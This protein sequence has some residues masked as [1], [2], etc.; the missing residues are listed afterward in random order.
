M[1][2]NICIRTCVLFILI[3]LSICLFICGQFS[4]TTLQSSGSNVCLSVDSSLSLHSSPVAQMSVCL[5]LV[6]YLYSLHSLFVVSSLS[7]H[8]S[9]VAQMS[10]CLWLILYHYT[11]VQWLKCLFVCGQFSIS[12]LYT[13]VQW[14]QVSVCLLLVLYPYTLV[15]WLKRLFVC[16]QVSTLYSSPVVQM[17]VCGQFS[18]PTLQSSDGQFSVACLFVS[19]KVIT[20]FWYMQVYLTIVMSVFHL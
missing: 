3:C 14:A 15:K 19:P 1:Y 20:I 8:S 10:V 17:S 5:W 7:L 6:L 16:V 13:L 9:P 18:I 2:E 12:I 11:L 4:I